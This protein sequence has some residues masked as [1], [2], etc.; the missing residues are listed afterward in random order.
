MPAL[1]A[2]R[3]H[4][5]ARS[6]PHPCAHT[7]EAECSAMPAAG[8]R[9]ALALGSTAA[10]AQTVSE[11]PVASPEGLTD[12]LWGESSTEKGLWEE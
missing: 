7:S 4:I 11:T 9:P 5:N 10:M 2:A 6:A 1:P 12:G 3:T 8:V